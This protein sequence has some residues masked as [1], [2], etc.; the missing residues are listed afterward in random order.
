[1]KRVL[2]VY[3]QINMGGTEMVFYNLIK[4]GNRK[5]FSYE[6]LVREEGNNET[7][8]TD[9][10]IT[11]HHIPTTSEKE[12]YSHLVNFFKKERFDVVHVHM[13]PLLPAVMKAA[14]AAGIPCRI[15][16]SHNARVDIPQYLWPLFY[17]KHHPY[18][19]YATHLF[20]CSELAL[21]WL[22]PTRWSKGHVIYNGID[23]SRFR[24]DAKIRAKVRLNNGIPDNT[25]VFINVGRCTEQKNQRFILDL[26]KERAYK[27]E[28]YIIIGD[29]PLY[30]ELEKYRNVNHID[31][32]RMLGTRTDVADWLNAADIFL[33]P[34]IYEGLGIVAIEAEATGLIVLAT[35]TIPPEA[36]MKLGNYH[37]LSLKDVAGWNKL[38]NLRPNDN[39]ERLRISQ[40]AL[41]SQFNISKVTQTVENI[42][43]IG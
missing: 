19:K 37:S 2:H 35:D 20:G 14:N 5:E 1:M 33:F 22:F 21:K 29:G 25:T 6:L 32:V 10:G 18:E 31:N 15:A 40:N 8:F 11:I 39:A 23:L 28:L 12:Y 4:F 26:A 9:L 36:D 16:H 13:E 24:F 43:S 17:F 27:N 38:M 34:S 7:I 30:D 42:Y 41:N 3:P